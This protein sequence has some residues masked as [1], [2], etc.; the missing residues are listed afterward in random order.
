MCYV[1]QLDCYKIRYTQLIIN[2]LKSILNRA[3]HLAA[4]F[5]VDKFNTKDYQTMCSL[6]K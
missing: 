1:S 4:G 5:K 3:V 2:M 6:I